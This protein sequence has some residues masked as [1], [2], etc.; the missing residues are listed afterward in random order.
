MLF[1]PMLSHPVL[2]YPILCY[3]NPIFFHLA[4]SYPIL[5]YLM[6]SYLM[7]AYLFCLCLFY[8]F[9]FFPLVGLPGFLFF[10]FF[11]FWTGWQWKA[12]FSFCSPFLL[13][14]TKTHSIFA[15][16]DFQYYHLTLSALWT[17]HSRHSVCEISLWT[18]QHP[19][20]RHVWNRLIDFFWSCFLGCSFFFYWNLAFYA[21]GN[22]Q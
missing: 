17:F 10:L 1:Y 16:F 8:C 2:S 7:P 3:P 21:D 22:G 19:L 5:L 9:S 12:F 4:P 18:K 15:C 6:L 14:L 20:F 11:F 13:P